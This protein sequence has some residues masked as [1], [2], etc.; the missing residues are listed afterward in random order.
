MNAISPLLRLQPVE[1]LINF[2]TGHIRRFVESPNEQTKDSF[3]SLFGSGDFRQ[4]LQGLSRQDREDA[5]VKAYSENVKRT[6]TFAYC[7]IAIVLCPE[8][9]QTHFHLIYATRNPKGVEVFK[10]VEK[11]AIQVMERARAEAQQRRRI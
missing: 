3:E 11:K 9:D 6:G 7:C 1:V 5:L 2:M 10:E 4:T 8:I